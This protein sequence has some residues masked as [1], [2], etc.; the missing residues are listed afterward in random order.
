MAK[1]ESS[2]GAAWGSIKAFFLEH[3]PDHLDDRDY[4]AYRLVK[5]AMDHFYGPQDQGWETYK[6]QAKNNTTYVRKKG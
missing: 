5:K 2:E 3:L 1:I 6:N 4:L